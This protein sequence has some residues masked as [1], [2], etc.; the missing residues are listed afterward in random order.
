M[1]LRFSVTDS[2]VGMPADIVE[3]MMIPFA[4]AESSARRS[5]QGPGLG[6]SIVRRLL[7][8]MGGELNIDSTPGKGTRVWFEIALSPILAEH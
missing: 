1:R 3:H 4:K 6:L 5:L 2:G 8:L 7:N